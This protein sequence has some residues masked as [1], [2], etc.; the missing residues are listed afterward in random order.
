MAKSKITKKG[1]LSEGKV[2]RPLS[3]PK[4]KPKK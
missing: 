3:K 4:P 2:S 1:R